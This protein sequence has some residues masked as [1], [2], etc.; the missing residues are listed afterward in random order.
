MPKSRMPE[1]TEQNL[2]TL[3]RLNDSFEGKTLVGLLHKANN[4]V[5][6]S[7]RIQK[8]DDFRVEQG[9]GQILDELITL[10][11]KAGS[12]HK[13]LRESKETKPRTF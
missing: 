11:E 6:H 10:L 13:K 7:L 9:A 1:M 3:A 8:G 5:N 4:G 12:I 2:G